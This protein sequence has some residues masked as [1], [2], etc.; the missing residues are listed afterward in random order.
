MDI[1]ARQQPFLGFLPASCPSWLPRIFELQS[2]VRAREFH[3]TSIN[4]ALLG[5]ND[6]LE[7]WCEDKVLR[8][9]L[10]VQVAKL[11]MEVGA[12]R[13]AVQALLDE[14]R[15]IKHQEAR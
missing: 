4:R 5:V 10:T 12:E 2:Q 15:R 11:K 1:S 7:K 13:Q 3:L 8:R 14:E 9:L 6:Y